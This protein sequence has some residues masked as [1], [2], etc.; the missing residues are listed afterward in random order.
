MVTT[1]IINETFIQR[2]VTRDSKIINDTQKQVVGDNLQVKSG[3][4]SN[5]LENYHFHIDGTHF[6]FQTLNYL[7]FLDIRYRKDRLSERRNLALYNR[8]IWGVLYHETMPSLRYGL[9]EDIKT[10]IRE[11]LIASMDTQQTIQFD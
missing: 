4:L 3:K 2:I 6:V 5:F 7:R 11:Q 9:T 8:V 1:E 10:K